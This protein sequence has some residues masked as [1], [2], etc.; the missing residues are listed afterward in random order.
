MARNIEDGAIFKGLD[1]FDGGEGKDTIDESAAE[2]ARGEGPPG[3]GQQAPPRQLQDARRHGG[4]FAVHKDGY[5]GFLANALGKAG[6]VR[7]GV[8]EDDGF[9][10]LENQPQRLDALEE[11]EVVAGEAGIHEGEAAVLN[12]EIPVERTGIEA[13]N[14]L[15]DLHGLNLLIVLASLKEAL[16][17][18]LE[19]QL[20]WDKYALFGNYGNDTKEATNT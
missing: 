2:H 14:A 10:I 7:V 11:G 1:L 3:I 9:E 13:M 12:D 16:D 8:G 4:I 15:G 18:R 20:P 6:V 17:F 19:G 5:A